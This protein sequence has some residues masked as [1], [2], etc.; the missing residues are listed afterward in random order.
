MPAPNQHLIT[1]LNRVE[2]LFLI[3]ISFALVV[4]SWLGF[5]NNSWMVGYIAV[6]GILTPILFKSHLEAS[7]FI[8]QKPWA[9]WLKVISPAIII[10]IIYAVGL[11]FP[12][13]QIVVIGGETFDAFSS[14][15]AWWLPSQVSLDGSLNSQTGYVG[16]YLIASLLLF[17]PRT[18]LF[19][20]RLMQ[21]LFINNLLM[22]IIYILGK[23]IENIEPLSS[24]PTGLAS[25][26]SGS[27]SWAAFTL[28]WILSLWGHFLSHFRVRR[29]ERSFINDPRWVLPASILAIIAL[30]IE[31]DK[32]LAMWVF[33][34]IALTL[35]HYARLIQRSSRRRGRRKKYIWVGTYAL[36][37]ISVIAS[38]WAA[39]EVSLTLAE[40][41]SL[42]DESQE[43]TTPQS[44]SLEA[45]F[46]MISERPVTGW[47]MESFQQIGHFFTEPIESKLAVPSSD[48]L[49]NVLQ[50]G[51]LGCLILAWVP[52][53]QITKY[54]T[55]RKR[56]SVSDYALLAI[57]MGLGFGIAAIPTL[58]GSYVYLWLIILFTG[59]RWADINHEE[60][61][62]EVRY[63]QNVRVFSQ[64]RT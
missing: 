23:I 55:Q 6:L 27:D 35:S 18:K 49:L 39:S 53:A 50:F 31:L 44:A 62:R 45:A 4:L 43:E 26:L 29:A 48:L 59:I 11:F 32:W 57:G 47:G 46:R 2:I 22:C 51:I 19:F 63:Q 5:E 60:D 14:P 56:N 8:H 21:V 58:Q 38:L 16:M 3:L 40:N 37:L 54:F 33:S 64:K 61:L 30:L 41:I 20:E 25:N 9:K 13:T 10:S 42:V 28:I 7:E 36:S 15:K 17:I 52:I 24:L 12:S 1:H 34:A